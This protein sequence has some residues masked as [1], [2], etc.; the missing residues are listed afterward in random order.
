MS[1]NL[2]IDTI[3]HKALKKIKTE[4]ENELC[5]YLPSNKGGYIHHFSFRKLK[6]RDPQALK[7]L[8]EEH[9]LNPVSPQ[10]LPANTRNPRGSRK[11]N[12]DIRLSQFDIQ[13]LCILANRSGDAEMAAKLT[14]KSR[15]PAQLRRDLM[16]SIRAGA[17]LD[18][19]QVKAYNLAH[20]G[21]EKETSAEHHHHHTA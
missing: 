5:R 3:I 20:G 15:T 1:T 17:S 6:N 21:D 12:H 19:H 14:A 9:V 13:K 18:A 16:R 10:P 4:D 8:I 2:S 7:A 11:G